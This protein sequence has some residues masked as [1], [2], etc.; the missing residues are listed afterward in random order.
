[1]P[2]FIWAFI[3]A[4]AVLAV[5][6]VALIGY[7]LVSK[8]GGTPPSAAGTVDTGSPGTEQGSLGGP[9]TATPSPDVPISG[10][11]RCRRG[12]EFDVSPEDAA[13]AIDGVV[14]GKADDW[15][16]S[17]G[18]KVYYFKGPGTY[19]VKLSMRGYRTAYVHVI[20]SPQAA[21]DVISVDTELRER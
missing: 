14:I 12:A 5:V 7:G 3:G 17:G 13:V 19:L 16:G 9:E 2:P 18:G 21:E 6:L 11:F 4:A 20:V 1:M 8:K 15:D 10:T